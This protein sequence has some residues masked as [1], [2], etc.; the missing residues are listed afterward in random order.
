MTLL[1]YISIPVWDTSL[2]TIVKKIKLP[3][4]HPYFFY[5]KVTIDELSKPSLTDYFKN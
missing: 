1:S 3:I 5:D 4:D 2:N